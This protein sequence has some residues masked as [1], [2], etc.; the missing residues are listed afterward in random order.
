MSILRQ[1]AIEM[2]NR[3]PEDKMYYVINILAS[4]EG[5]M[6]PADM[7]TKTDSQTAYEELKQYRKKGNIDRNYKEE[8]YTALE[9]KYAG[10][11]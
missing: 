6:T 4:I 10:T 8:L 9:E 7:E 3:I 11:Y 5:L 2:V 1:Q